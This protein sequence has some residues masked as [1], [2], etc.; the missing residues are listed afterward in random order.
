MDVAI[1]LRR[2]WYKS[3]DCHHLC[4]I[5]YRHFSQGGK[6]KLLR[7]VQGFLVDTHVVLAGR[8][9]GRIYA[10]TSDLST[11]LDHITLHQCGGVWCL[12]LDDHNERVAFGCGRG[13]VILFRSG[14]RIQFD[15]FLEGPRCPWYVLS[16]HFVRDG[17]ILL[18]GSENGTVWASRSLDGTLVCSFQLRGFLGLSEIYS[19]ISLG[20]EPVRQA[21]ILCACSGLH[22]IRLEEKQPSVFSF[23]P[24]SIS[25]IPESIFCL[26]LDEQ[27]NNVLCGCENGSIIVYSIALYTI[28]R[29]VTIIEDYASIWSLAICSQSDEIFV[30]WQNNHVCFLERESCMLVRWLT[31]FATV[32]CAYSSKHHDGVYFGDNYGQVTHIDIQN[33][34]GILH[35]H[36][37]TYAEQMDS[38][39]IPW[40][41]CSCLHNAEYG[42]D[43]NNAQTLDQLYDIWCIGTLAISSDRQ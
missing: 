25:D 4:L 1:A 6:L 34:V 15:I 22:R 18:A 38:V 16:V 11:I 19:M 7:I 43:C 30:G 8:R 39:H 23:V 13:R 33:N 26:A 41:C 36:H 21:E 17:E 32:S 37:I 14:M 12:A 28:I 9:D 3:M 20:S 35:R 10:L 27:S 24:V 40:E 42:G 5:G 31:N 2:F 29:V